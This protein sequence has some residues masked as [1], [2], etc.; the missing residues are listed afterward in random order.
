[1]DA[2]RCMGCGVCVNLCPNSAITLQRAP[3]KGEPLEII[4]LINQA[5]AV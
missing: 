4:N 2:G 1:V 3:Q 5:G